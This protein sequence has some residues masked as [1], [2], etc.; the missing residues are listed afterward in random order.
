MLLRGSKRL[1]VELESADYWDRWLIYG[2]LFV[3]GVTCVWIVYKRILRG[4][5][6]LVI[7]GMGKAFGSGAAV[8]NG[9]RISSAVGKSPV[10]VPTVATVKVTNHATMESASDAVEGTHG[11]LW[12]EGVE[13]EADVV[14]EHV[15]VT[16]SMDHTT[17]NSRAE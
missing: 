13:P 9:G 15:P 4:P 11:A 8:S 5:V 1:I 2:G 6:G 17:A 16:D 3:F 7:W 14:A 12:S 10:S